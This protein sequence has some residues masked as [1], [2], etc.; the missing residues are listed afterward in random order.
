MVV[1]RGECLSRCPRH[2]A[3]RHG[4]RQSKYSFVHVWSYQCPTITSKAGQRVTERV[5]LPLQ[6]PSTGDTSSPHH[7][8]TSSPRH[9]IVSSQRP[10][11]SF[12][13]SNP[14]TSCLHYFRAICRQMSKAQ[15]PK[16]NVELHVFSSSETF[17]DDLVEM[18]A[19]IYPLPCRYDIPDSRPYGSSTVRS[20]TICASSLGLVRNYLRGKSTP[21]QPFPQNPGKTVELPMPLSGPFLVQG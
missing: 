1:V 15:R 14:P 7:P 5:S 4:H 13:H 17:G 6:R 8:I 16:E 9:L 20:A 18:P 10:I 19:C 3:R 11:T 21:K 12:P 2:R